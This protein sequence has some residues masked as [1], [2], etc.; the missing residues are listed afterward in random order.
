MGS[1][2]CP[3]CEEEV[4]PVGWQDAGEAP[5]LQADRYEAQERER[6]R[7]ATETR[8]C[9]GCGTRL[10]RTPPGHWYESE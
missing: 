5:P 8:R 3:K 6:G 4:E 1:Y 7:V 9:P 10:A 2:S